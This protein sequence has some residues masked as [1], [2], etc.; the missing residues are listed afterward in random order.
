MVDLRRTAWRKSSKSIPQGNDC[1]EV[2]APVAGFVALRDS[3][4][5]GGPTLVVA[6]G[7]WGAFVREVKDGAYDLR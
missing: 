6:G 4:D 3:N 5:P 7:A 1:V 2:A